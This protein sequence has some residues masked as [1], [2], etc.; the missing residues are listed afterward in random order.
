MVKEGDSLPEFELLNHKGEKVSSENIEEAVI[1]FYP[2]A[3]TQ[4]C[5][6]E[7]CEFRDRISE[8]E[9][10]E[11]SVY[12]V[13]TDSVESQETFHENNNLNF[14]LLSDQGG[15]V[16]GNF[17]VLQDSGYAERTTFVVSEGK[18]V[19]SFRKV[20][21]ANHVDQLLDYLQTVDDI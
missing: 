1:Y 13:S 6:K 17:N 15:I 4:G 5:T 12:G 16:C 14:D 7:A 20:N 3:D 10:V 8:L 9:K 21:P 11:V 19:K 18:I 2:K